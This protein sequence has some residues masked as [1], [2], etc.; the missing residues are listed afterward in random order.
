MI[1]ID[2][3]ILVRYLTRDSEFRLPLQGLFACC[4]A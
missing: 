3:N 1:G 2:T 4:L